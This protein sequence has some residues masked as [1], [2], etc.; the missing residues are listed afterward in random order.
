[1]KIYVHLVGLSIQHI[2]TYC[3]NVYPDGNV[4]SSV[5]SECGFC[6]KVPHQKLCVQSLYLNPSHLTTNKRMSSNILSLVEFLNGHQGSG[7]IITNPAWDLWS[8]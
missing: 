2:R 7:Q 1:M 5:R 6:N 4:A 3:T 8:S